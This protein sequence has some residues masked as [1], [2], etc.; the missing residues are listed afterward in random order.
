MNEDAFYT[1]VQEMYNDL[2]LTDRDADSRGSV[3]PNFDLDAFAN[4]DYYENN[5]AG[6][7][8]NDLREATNYGFARAPVEL[9]K[10]V[11]QNNRPF[12]EIVTAD[13]TMVNPYSAV[14]YNNN[15]GDPNFPFS[16]DQNQANHDRDDF[17]AATNI[18]QQDN[19]L[20]P[21]AGVIGTHAFLARY[22]STSTNV[23]RARSRYVFDYF[24]GLDIESLAARDGLDLDNVIGSVP[25]F[26]DPQCTVCHVVMDPIAGLFT[27]RDNDGEY[28]PGNTFQH[29]RTSNGV[30]RMVPAGYSL[31]QADQLPVSE[32]DTALQWLGGRLAQDDRFAER[33]VRTVFKGLTGIEASVASTT[34]FVNA[35]KN[36]FVAANFNFKLLVKDIIASDYFRARNLA[37]GEDPNDY[38]DTGAGRLLT[39]EEL[40]RKISD[41]TGTNYEWRGPNSNSGLLGRHR[42]LY[43]G[44]DSE[45]VI[46]RTTEPTSLIDGIQERIANQVACQ[47]V[48]N[49]LYNGGAL[50]PFVDATDIP[51]GGAGESAIR[52]NIQ[53]LHRR[54]LGED[55]APNDAEIDDTYQ[56]FVDVR[57]AGESAIQSQCRGGGGSTDNNGT[58]I[59]WMAVV[60]Y[61]L[62]DYR[63]LYE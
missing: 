55:L 26:E 11:I 46:L 50:F 59:P 41:I 42:L 17:R 18:R 37:L 51:D 63:F 44:I 62:A 30:P 23:N 20:V 19:T 47:R 39:P 49:D 4:R 33:T 56:L 36:Q 53:F 27:N 5:F 29:T 8:L 57:A 16:S 12:T 58:V 14:I 9:V 48:A 45:D 10:Y 54:I 1:R 13:Y 15:A 28:D 2:L 24:L 40:N 43:G 35:I 31:L 32:E 61:L 60:T 6:S 38:A 52:Q 34:A 22:P 7:E 21:A 25:T 3:D